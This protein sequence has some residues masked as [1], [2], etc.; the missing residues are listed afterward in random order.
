ML[1]AHRP[2][3]RRESARSRQSSAEEIWQRRKVANVISPS[4]E[5]S[6]HLRVGIVL[7]PAPPLP[8]F[9][10]RQMIHDRYELHSRS[11][12]S[13]I[14]TRKERYS[15]SVGRTVAGRVLLTSTS[16]Q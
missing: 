9:P 8:L 1:K 11:V 6:S 2:M 15:Q 7:L 4:L 10:S 14:K 5:S 3:I 12:R 13:G 16:R